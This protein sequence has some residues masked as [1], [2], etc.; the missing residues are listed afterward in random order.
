MKLLNVVFNGWGERW[1]LGVLADDG[2]DILFEYA[3]EALRRGIEFSPRHLPLRAEG[4]SGFPSHQQRLPGLLADSLPDGWGMLLMDKLFRKQGRAHGGISP[5]DRLAFVGER[6]MGALRCVRR[7]GP[8]LRVGDAG[9]PPC[10]PGS[11][12]GRFRRPALRPGGWRAGAG[13]YAR[14]SAACRLPSAVRRLQHLSD[15]DDHAKNF[16]YRMARDG[17]WRLSPCYDLSFNRGPGG[18]HQMAV[19]GESKA[20][21]LIDLLRLAADAG[22]PERLARDSI[23][24]TPR[25]EVHSR[26]WRATHRSAPPQSTPSTK[27]SP[28]T[29]TGWRNRAHSKTAS[30]QSVRR[31]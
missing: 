24:A 14:R 20:P 15:R 11:S 18:E 28:R 30:L 3:P 16:S 19:M 25:T 9:H 8:P 22:V 7:V 17:H 31:Q 12:L 29:A 4:F 27:P 23:E 26:R 13:P 2:R 6:G 10:R 1:P 21:G 5:L